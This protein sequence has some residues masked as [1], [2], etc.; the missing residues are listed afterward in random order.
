MSKWQ[1]FRFNEVFDKDLKFKSNIIDKY[2]QTSNIKLNDGKVYASGDIHGD[3]YLFMNILLDLSNMVTIDDAEQ[4]NKFLKIEDTKTMEEYLNSIIDEPKDIGLKWKGENK[5]IVFCGD[6]VD[7]KRNEKFNIREKYGQNYIYFP[8]IK[9]LYIIYYL[10][11]HSKDKNG[12]IKVCGNHDYGNLNNPKEKRDWISN[13]SFVFQDELVYGDDRKNYFHYDLNKITSRLLF[14][15]IFPLVKINEHYFMHGGLDAEH[16]KDNINVEKLNQ[17]FIKCIINKQPTCDL[18]EMMDGILWD[19]S[20]SSYF[21]CTN[22]IPTEYDNIFEDKIIIVGHCPFF[23]TI[24]DN[25]CDKSKK[26]KLISIFPKRKDKFRQE[27]EIEKKD[28]ITAYFSNN[29]EP[30]CDG[31]NHGIS[32]QFW[33][34][35]RPKLFRLDTGMGHAFDSDD[36]FN[37][38]EEYGLDSYNVELIGKE[39]YGRLP[40]ILCID[41]G[42]N[43]YTV[44]TATVHNALI[45]NKRGMF[46]KMEDKDIKK[47]VFEV[48]LINKDINY[49]KYIKYKMK[50]NNLKKM[51]GGY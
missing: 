14:H 44:K 23:S 1:F 33:D 38:N 46:G 30:T 11:Y 45:T 26:E 34:K 39:Y 32:A 22:I 10:N 37:K 8:E 16:F 2:V 3:Y 5:F 17:D 25:I 42:D 41:I 50:Y 19:R 24:Y 36:L 40:Q 51:L 31:K 35:T 7:N 48:G 29:Y 47:K 43:K 21:F 12:I 9:I 13:Y 20:F 4:Y 49:K 27:S 15:M 28:V 6:I 18:F